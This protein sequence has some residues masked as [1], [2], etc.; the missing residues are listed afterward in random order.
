[1]TASDGTVIDP[2]TLLIAAL[3]GLIVWMGS[4]AVLL[5]GRARS[6]RP[7]GVLAAN[8]GG[9]ALAGLGP[10]LVGAVY[11]VENGSP[12]MLIPLAVVSG[13]WVGGLSAIAISVLRRD[14]ASE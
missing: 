8:A 12:W 14:S 9:M 6:V 1:V 11:V 5:A 3:P 7:K 13:P 4:V 2:T 10:A